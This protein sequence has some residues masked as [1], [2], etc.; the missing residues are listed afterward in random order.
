MTRSSSFHFVTPEPT[1][2]TVPETSCPKIC[3]AATKPCS[4]FFRSVPQIPHDATRINTSPGPI[5]GTGTVSTTTFPLPRYTAARIVDG[6]GRAACEVSRIIPDWL[7]AQPPYPA[8][9]ES[10]GQP[11]FPQTRRG[12]R[13]DAWT[14]IGNGEP[15]S[16]G[17]ANQLAS[18]I[19]AKP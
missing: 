5:T 12:S 4:I 7:I 15:I 9:W 11:S 13:Q 14:Q 6:T 2:T 1:A 19:S 3:G 10:G 18:A 8:R 17:L 16:T